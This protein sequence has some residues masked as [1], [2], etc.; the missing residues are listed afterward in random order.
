MKKFAIAFFVLLCM[1][2]SST[3]YARGGGGCLAKGTQV[4]TPSGS[5]AIDKLRLGDPV[6]SIRAGKLQAKANFSSPRSIR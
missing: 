3:A 6:W 1:F 2:A 5:T 4:L